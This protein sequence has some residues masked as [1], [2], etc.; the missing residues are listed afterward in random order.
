MQTQT[1]IKVRFTLGVFEVLSELCLRLYFKVRRLVG[2]NQGL[3]DCVGRYHN[4]DKTRSLAL[5]AAAALTFSCVPRGSFLPAP[6]LPPCF[7]LRPCGSRSVP[8]VAR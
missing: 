6:V 2:L 3:N 4:T 7:T 8:V 1:K 5:A